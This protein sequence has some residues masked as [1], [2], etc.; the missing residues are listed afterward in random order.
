MW[1]SVKQKRASLSRGTSWKLVL[2]SK[3]TSKIEITA[4]I[5][6]KCIVVL[7]ND[8]LWVISRRKPDN[9]SCQLFFCFFFRGELGFVSHCLSCL[10]Q[11]LTFLRNNSALW[12]CFDP[13]L[14]LSICI[15]AIFP[16]EVGCG[17]LYFLLLK[18]E[19]GHFLAQ[20]NLRFFWKT[21]RKST[22][23]AD[24]QKFLCSISKNAISPL[25]R[26][27][28]TKSTLTSSLEV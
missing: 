6:S 13:N 20:W 5:P 16:E 3:L 26:S 25:F 15:Y 1:F 24:F 21:G 22:R 12:C 8:I 4:Q 10:Y 27:V 23:S 17:E 18:I 2:I 7:Q 28:N 19:G 14:E 9:Y 11:R